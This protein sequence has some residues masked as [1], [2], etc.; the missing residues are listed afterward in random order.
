[1]DVITGNVERFLFKN[2]ENS[3]G[4]FV[5]RVDKHQTITA[6]GY[7]SGVQEGSSVELHGTWTMHAKFGKQFEA[8]SCIVSLP[9]SIE[10]LKK[11]LSSGIIKGIGKVYAEKLVATFG[12]S[13]LTTIEHNPEKLSQIP[14]I[15]PKRIEE[16]SK[17]WQEQKHIAHIMVFLQEKGASSSYAT[18]IYKHYGTNAISVMTENPYR[19]AQEVWGIGFKTADTIAQQLGFARESLARIKAGILFAINQETGNGHLY[20]ELDAL[21]EHTT[22]LLELNSSTIKESLSNALYQLHHEKHIVLITHQ[23]KHYITLSKYYWI[24]KG[25][26]KKIDDLLTYPI[27]TFNHNDAFTLLQQAGVGSIELTEQQQEGILRALEYKISIVTGGPG[28]GKTTLVKQLLKILD[29]KKLSYKLAAPTGR[30]AKRITESTGSYAVTLHRLLEFN[31]QIMGFTHNE[32]NALQLDFLIVDESSM[33]D[34]FLAHALFK[35]LPLT[36]HILFLGDIDQLPSVGAGNFL[37]DLIASKK[38]VTTRLKYIF[39]QAENSLI[40]YNAHRINQGNFPESRVPQTIQDYYFIKEDHPENLHLHLKKAIFTLLPKWRISTDRTIV[41]S[42]MNRGSAGTHTINDI[43]QGML[44]PETNIP[45]LQKQFQTFKVGDR[46]MQI[47]NNYDKHVFNG[48]IGTITDI[49]HTDTTMT[50]TYPDKEVTY[51]FLETDELILAYAISIHKSQGSEFDAVIIPIFTQHF[52]ML[53]RNLVYTAMTRAK[54]LCILI[55]QPRALAIAIKN[56]K[57]SARNTFLA[58]FLTEDLQCR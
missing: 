43:L 20:V 10:G 53:Q 25:I 2:P 24:E 14:G 31:P 58:T 47:K 45:T 23:E 56:V 1:M 7:A 41:L 40:A 52:T 15:G 39:R 22:T 35:A 37:H 5:V 21:K 19:I 34:V 44:N 50:V 13:V 29:A 30:A 17:G 48:D 28:T 49:N 42:P 51:D 54:K 18:K 55:G 26:A 27:K 36:A 9:Q 12:T 16:I 4:V 33:I 6:R 8:S 46:V 3:F 32:Q 57:S 38:I 11:Y